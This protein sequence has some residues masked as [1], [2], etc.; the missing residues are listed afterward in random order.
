MGLFDRFAGHYCPNCGANL[1]DQEGYNPKVPIW[2]CA[3]CGMQLTDPNDPDF[4]SEYGESVVWYCDNCDAVLNKQ[5]GFNEDCGIWECTNCGFRNRINEDFIYDDEEEEDEDLHSYKE[6]IRNLIRKEDNPDLFCSDNG[7]TS[8]EHEL[9]EEDFN[10]DEILYCEDCGALLNAQDGFYNYAYSWVCTNCGHINYIQEMYDE[11]ESDEEDDLSD[12]DESQEIEDYED[13]ENECEDV[14]EESDYEEISTYVDPE[15]KRLRQEQEKIKIK[16]ELK[17]QQRKEA[18]KDKKRAFR[19]KHWKGLLIFWLIVILIMLIGSFYLYI[20]YQHSLLK[21][22]PVSSDEVIGQNYEAVEAAFDN[23]GFVD[24]ESDDISDLKISEKDHSYKVT[25]VQVGDMTT[26]VSG[27]KIKFDTPILIS[28]HTVKEI[29]TP[30]GSKDVKKKDYKEIEKAME[31]QGFVNIKT[32][33]KKDLIT[34][35]IT[36]ENS[37]IS[38]TIDGEEDYSDGD[39]FMPDAEVVIIYHT[40]KD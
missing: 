20:Q 26:F 11:R 35:W 3:E 23:A 10:E 7:S 28:Y 32:K 4:D 8:E 34:G 12:D 16:K 40:F 9:T 14:D 5:P 31:D 29:D 39:F 38:M 36:K 19:H 25:S 1:D 6:Q 17:R 27:D 33:A 30:Y 22:I 24:V 13:N 15:L 37:V 21:R 2:T 18:R